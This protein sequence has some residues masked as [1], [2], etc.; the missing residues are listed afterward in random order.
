MSLAEALHR[1]YF[2][3]ASWPL[4]EILRWRVWASLQA[5]EREREKA[6]RGR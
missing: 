4:D 1:P 5:E 6:E 2:E 3:L